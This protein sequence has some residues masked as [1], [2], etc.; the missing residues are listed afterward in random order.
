MVLR[1]RKDLIC[2]SHLYEEVKEAAHLTTLFLLHLLNGKISFSRRSE[3][4][5][6]PFIGVELHLLA[7]KSHRSWF[8]IVLVPFLKTPSMVQYSS[9]LKSLLPFTIN[10]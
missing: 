8:G 3:K 6:S 5:L 1:V 9:G 7:I 2:A 4:Q 10:D